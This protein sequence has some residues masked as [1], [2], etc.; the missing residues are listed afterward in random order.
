MMK[1]IEVGVIIIYHNQVIFL[2]IIEEH[3]EIKILIN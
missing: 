3:L 1:I 2:K